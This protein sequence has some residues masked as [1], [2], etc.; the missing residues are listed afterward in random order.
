VEYSGWWHHRQL[1]NLI[2]MVDQSVGMESWVEHGWQLEGS[3]NQ[4]EVD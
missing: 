2:G 1:A 4:V 3:H